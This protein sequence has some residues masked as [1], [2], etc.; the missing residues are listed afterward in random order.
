MNT[1][2]VVFSA[3]S[4][5][6]KVA[7]FAIERAATEKARLILLDV[8]DQDVSRKVGEMVAD[9]GFMGSTVTD[10][11]RSEIKEQRARVIERAL[12]N[13]EE[14]AREKGVEVEVGILKGPS[15]DRIIQIAKERG[16]STLIVQKRMKQ[17]DQEAPFEVIRLKH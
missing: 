10:Q 8:R 13:I 5:S 16:V 4:I 2:M 14:Q 1:I 12:R 9:I 7:R 15:A 3:T 11:L 6:E 17:A